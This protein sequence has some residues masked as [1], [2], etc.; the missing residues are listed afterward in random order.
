MNIS[1][2]KEFK[3]YLITQRHSKR[4]HEQQV[5]ETFLNDTYRL[6]LTKKE[7]YQLRTQFVSR[8]V[9]AITQQLITK[10]PKV[11]VEP[12]DSSKQN[13]R[14]SASK[15]A[16][17]FNRWVKTLL[18]RANNPFEQ[19]FK[20]FNVRGESWLYF[21]HS[22]KLASYEGDWREDYPEV[23]PVDFILYDPLI[24][25]CD[26]SDESEGYPSKVVVSYQRTIADI[27][28][29]YPKWTKQ[30]NRKLNETVEFFLY[31]DKSMSYAE[32][33]D[34]PLFRNEKGILLNGSGERG[35]PYG[36]MPFAHM[37]SGWGYETQSKDPEMLAYSRIRML[38]SMITEDSQVRSDRQYNFH[39]FA[40]R[41]KT[42]YL[43]A[44]ADLAP[45][46]DANFSNDPDKLNYLVLPE[47]ANPDWFKPDE[48]LLFSAEAYAYADRISSDLSMEF[49]MP[50]RG[51][52][53]GTSGRQEDI[54]RSS[55]LSIYDTAVHNTAQLWAKGFYQALKVSDA[56]PDMLPQ[57]V[58]GDD[59]ERCREVIVDLRTE[60]KIQRDREIT[61][62]RVL[63]N[64]GKRS[65]KTFL[66]QDM[67]LTEEE[68]DNEID[69]I[70]AEKYMLENPEIAAFLGFKATQKSGMA[71]ELD[72]WKQAN[73]QKPEQF[74]LGSKI[75]SRGGEPRT[76]NIKTQTGAEMPDVALGGLGQRGTP[77]G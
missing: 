20:N 41:S 52:A 70:L 13:Q 26:P 44:G 5:D 62:G 17:L 15:L 59:I 58:T 37:Y 29:H 27:L 30:E 1:E 6:P 61:M 47:G 25:F 32:A 57:G 45:D 10:E 63:V 73:Q 33:A 28:S 43:P 7:D 39:G 50:L 46:W 34:E 77:M 72:Q 55:G 65:L 9:N 75:G 3:T 48:S 60:D 74:T 40:H 69:E 8:M 64:E 22:S 67:R 71:E 76:L 53:G 2:I 19:T 18:E 68:A 4:I 31:F 42:L 21:P 56:L 23:I 16:V 35:N 49:P 36:C 14:D 38:R 51:T 54:L 11:Y 66:M 12:K 24:V